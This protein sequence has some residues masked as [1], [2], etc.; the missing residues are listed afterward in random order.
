[1]STGESMRVYTSTPIVIEHPLLTF[2][3]VQSTVTEYP[4]ITCLSLKGDTLSNHH[5][6]LLN[7]SMA[8]LRIN[9][10]DPFELPAASVGLPLGVVRT[11]Y[12]PHS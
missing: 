12:G 1:M 2:R 11:L 4:S 3:F 7:V 5:C 8:G 6:L 10:S 9:T